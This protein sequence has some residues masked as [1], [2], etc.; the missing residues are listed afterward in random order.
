MWDIISTTRSKL[1][2]VYLYEVSYANQSKIRFTSADKPIVFEGET[3]DRYPVKHGRLTVSAAL[4]RTSLDIE[5]SRDNPMVELFR[6]RTPEYVVNIK[7]LKGDDSL[8]EFRNYWHGRVHNFTRV[9]A[10][11]TFACEPVSTQMRRP[12]LRRNYQAGCPLVLYGSQCRANRV[13]FQYEATVN[14]IEDGKVVLMDGWLPEGRV[15]HSFLGGLL[16]WQ[17]EDGE[18]LRQLTN[19]DD[20]NTWYLDS[21]SVGLESGDT[22]FMA[23]GC[24][25]TLVACRD[26]FNNALNYG[27][28]PWIPL[29]NPLGPQ[30]NFY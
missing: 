7:I 12:G 26:T 4:D 14:S 18:L 20:D 22:V 9:G 10:K 27:G 15:A 23:M 2:P 24:P 16:T 5:T 13:E 29:D 11:V 30:N 19:N 1:R 8:S 25:H 17:G 6:V 28:Q 21:S 3:Y